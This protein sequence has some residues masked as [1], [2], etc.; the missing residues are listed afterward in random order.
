M[1]N[2]MSFLSPQAI[3][4][5]IIICWIAVSKVKL[6]YSYQDQLELERPSI[7]QMNFRKIISIK[8]IQ[9]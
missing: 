7:S 6:I 9:I 1:L 8:Y 3:Q 2:F 4:L 5:G